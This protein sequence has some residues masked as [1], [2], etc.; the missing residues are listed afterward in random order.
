MHIFLAIRG[1]ITLITFREEDKLRSSPL[2]DFLH[3]VV[4]STP[5]H[6]PEHAALKG[7]YF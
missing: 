1:L 2:R 6:L 7:L 4:T 3:P 5:T